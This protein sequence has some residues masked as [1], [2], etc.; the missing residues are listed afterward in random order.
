MN[1]LLEQEEKPKA[2][3][4]AGGAGVGKTFV[5]DK[6]K[7]AAESKGWVVLN[8][9]Q[10]ARNPDPEQRLSLAAAASKINKE[11]DSLAKSKDKPNIIWDTT[12]NNP[13]KVKELQ[14]AGY[15]V[16]M[17]MVYAHPSVAFEQNFAR[18]SKEG[19]DS[20]P[21]YVVLK[22]WADSYNDPHIENYQKMFGDNFI[23][24]DNT[25]KPGTDN[26]KIDAFNKAA[27][28]GGKALEKHIGDIIGSDPEYYSST[29]M[30]SKPAN[31][32]KEQQADFNS[33]VQEL[34]LKLKEDD[35]EAMEKLYQKYFEKNNEAMPLRKVGRK[36]GMEEVYKSYMSKK[37]KKDAEKSKVYNDISA[38]IKN[39]GKSFVSIDDAT[40]KAMAHIGQKKIN[41]LTQFLVDS[42][43]NEEEK[44]KRTVAIFAGGFKPP[45]KGHLEVVKKGVELAKKSPYGANIDEINIVVGGGVRD[46]ITQSQSKEIWELYARVFQDQFPIINVIAANPFD[47]YKEYLR[48]HPDD[49]VFVFIGSREGNEGD[50]ADVKFRSE[51]VKNYSD[52]VVPLHV[53]TAAVTSGTEARKYFRENDIEKFKNTLPSGLTTGNVGEIINILNDKS[54]NS[55]RKPAPKATEPL[56]PL[57]EGDP[58]KGTGKKPK[59]SGRRLYTD[60]DP[61]DTVGIKFS[62]RQ[63]IVDTLNKKSFK[64]KS[65]AR[66]SQIIN[67][68]HQRV[69]AAYGR[70][71]DPAV[72]KRLKTGLDYITSKKEASKKKTQRLKKQKSKNEN[73]D[74]KSQS[75]HKGK[76]APFG[77][78]YEPVDEG[79][80]YEKM[81]AKGKKAGSLKQGTVRK[82]LK[83][84]KDKKIPLSLINK[85][86]S[87]LKKMDKDKDK[88]GVQLGDKNQK[89]YK[90]LQLSKTLKTT[91]NVN[92]SENKEYFN[93]QIRIKNDSYDDLGT[94]FNN[95]DGRIQKS[96]TS[97][98]GNPLIFNYRNVPSLVKAA[99]KAKNDNSEILIYND[100]GKGKVYPLTIENIKLIKRPTS[101]NENA[102]YTNHID[103]KQQIKD[104]TKHMIK[105]GMNILPLPRVIFKHSDVENASQFLGK[106]AYYSPSD[107]TVV[108]YTEG[109]HP[110]DIVRSFAHEMIHHIQNLE[111]RLHDISTTNTMED[112]HLNDIEREAY[113]RGNM[114][115]RNWTD[116]MDGEEVSSLNEN[117]API[118]NLKV[119]HSTDS[120]FE[121]FSLD[122]A[123]DGFWFTNDLDS[124]K[125][126]TAGASGGKYILTRY[127]TLKN[128]ASWDEYDKYSVGE[129][130][131]KGYDGVFLPD[132]G[133]ADY[134]VFDPKSI[135]KGNEEVSSLDEAIVGEKI[136][137]DNCG[138][139]WN[140]VDGGDDLYMCHKCGHD[141]EPKNRDPFGLKAFA[142]E[143][144][145]DFK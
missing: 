54:T 13:T 94:T 6:F 16:L 17:I 59:G 91:T 101:L 142:R 7:K 83:I 2:I 44:P 85:E 139:S 3:I 111:D 47:Y 23:I 28:Q 18:A 51:F 98:D 122:Y 24:I 4:M 102:T 82:R 55:M 11:V 65:H 36:N 115:F 45:T 124:L 56:T 20:L 119:Y 40:S 84:P 58:K 12:A 145:E 68:I 97:K 135:S 74:P 72:K 132:E 80:T 39:I 35:R 137:C 34:G 88:K 32:S 49:Q 57:N 38:S 46:G 96:S 87:R 29:Q 48:K 9:D 93:F 31:L 27:Q 104:L 114:V 1:I 81:A 26:S 15:D 99:F 131:N 89:Y 117:I 41:E 76:A 141:N 62:T 143:L 50:Q 14:D 5:T 126:K 69:R 107:M 138:W 53:P 19:E 123:W 70:A 129:L 71:K 37:V 10:Y 77:S 63:D 136:E 106:T 52:N 109:R 127:I 42:I 61:K 22:T 128:P 105:K 95:M 67:L 125:N 21:P 90:A 116:N 103:Y 134:L 144:M 33:K 121:D 112:D 133:R 78:A 113:T 60:E 25:S 92:E 140:I 110:K 30:V 100:E 118:K 64:A 66:Q 43:L 120:K 75:K 86:L 73:I 130:I 79:D 108:L 8:P